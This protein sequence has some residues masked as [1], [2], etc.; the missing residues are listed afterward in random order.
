MLTTLGESYYAWD[1]KMYE[2]DIIRA[3]IRPKVKAI[4]KLVGKHIREDKKTGLHVNP[5]SN[6]RFVL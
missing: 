2:S 4:G 3:C 5:D 1:G 6:I